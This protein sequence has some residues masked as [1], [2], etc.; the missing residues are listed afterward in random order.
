MI[1]PNEEQNLV[2]QISALNSVQQA[3]HQ[4]LTK[5]ILSTKHVVKEIPAGYEIDFPY[6]TSLFL[7]ISEWISLEHLCCPFFTFNLQVGKG[8]L[9]LSITGNDLVKQFL[10]EQ[11]QLFG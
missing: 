9:Q 1:E 5:Q 4:A 3:K 11:T 8:K 10:R 2:C 6:N 7:E